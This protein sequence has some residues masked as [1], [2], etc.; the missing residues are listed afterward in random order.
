[1]A[2][3]IQFDEKFLDEKTGETVYRVK[4]PEKYIADVEKPVQANSLAANNFLSIS[5]QIVAL[6]KNQLHEYEKAVAAEG[7]IAKQVI[8]TREKMGLDSGW[9]YNIPKQSMEKRDPPP[10]T[11]MI[12]EGIATPIAEINTVPEEIPGPEGARKNGD[13]VPQVFK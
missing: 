4:V 3:P 11:K 5:R 13:I 9:I 1:M 8:R 6:Q 7:E 10:D 12:G 2:D